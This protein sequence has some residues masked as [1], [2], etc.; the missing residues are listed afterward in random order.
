MI[1]D[2]PEILV[3]KLGIS[4]EIH[5]TESKRRLADLVLGLVD[6]WEGPVVKALKKFIEPEHK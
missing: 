1:F 4:E 2:N 6:T 3:K 5:K